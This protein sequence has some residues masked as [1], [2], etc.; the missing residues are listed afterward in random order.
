MLAWRSA[1]CVML[2]V[3]T[4]VAH[5]D[6]TF[7][8]DNAQSIQ[9]AIDLAEDGDE[10]VV[11]PGIYFE[12]IN[13][14]GKAI[15]IRSE[16]PSDPAIV[17]ATIVNAAQLGSPLTVVN[18]EGNDT[19][20]RGLTFTNGLGMPD[21]GG[22][23]INL[24]SP[25]IEDCVFIANAA[26]SGLGGGLLVRG[27]PAI[28]RCSFIA[29][30]ARQGGGI[31]VV[32]VDPADEMTIEHSLFSTNTSL[33]LGG[34]LSSLASGLVRLNS[35]TLVANSSLYGGG[36]FASSA[37]RMSSSRLLGNSATAEGGGVL[38]S[39]HVQLGQSVLAGNVSGG[40]GAGVRQTGGSLELTNCTVT[41]N[42]S[43]LSA[44]GALDCAPAAELLLINSIVWENLTDEQILAPGATSADRCVIQGGFPG[45]MIVT[46]DPKFLDPLGPDGVAGTTDDDLRLA[47]TS[48]CI[49]AAD[50][51]ALVRYDPVFDA[52]GRD[53]T[54]D[55]AMTVNTGT[56]PIEHADLGP[57]EFQE[58]LDPLCTS[59]VST[60][61]SAPGDAAYGVPDGIV[62]LSDLLYFVNGWE[63]GQYN[64]P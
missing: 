15:T 4:G 24:S 42:T 38:A 36:V 16:D 26:P 31:H 22:G 25:T 54:V 12:R 52:D 49:D 9:H 62:D 30:E 3:L 53:R 61:G 55:D 8:P 58:T 56:G 6:I 59:D 7:V 48:P 19:V 23:V 35:C 57:F 27:A 63:F 46:A 60:T 45:T 64:C 29:N 40:A 32:G 50:F 13:T 37:L 20:I 14:L 41:R 47:P 28:R 21:G 39:G 1:A 5:A 11:R 18:E 34:G 17:A 33:Q 43:G 44:T 10:I 2:L 51:D